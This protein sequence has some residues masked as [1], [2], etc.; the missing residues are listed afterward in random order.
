MRR[1]V[2]AGAPMLGLGGERSVS[3]PL[4]DHG[5]TARLPRSWGLAERRAAA[6]HVVASAQS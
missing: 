5:V 2:C 3:P 1:G 4:A 6:Q